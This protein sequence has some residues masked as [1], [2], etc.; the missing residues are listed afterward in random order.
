MQGCEFIHD[1]F[2]IFRTLTTLNNQPLDH[3]F[4]RGLKRRVLS[5]KFTLKAVHFITGLCLIIFSSFSFDSFGQKYP[6]ASIQDSLKENAD[7]VIRLHE[8][9]WDIKSA[10]QATLKR[11]VIYTILNEKGDDYAV[12]ASAY[13]NKSLLINNINGYLY[14][15]SGKE[16]R[17]FKKKDMEDLPYEDGVSFV[18]DERIKRGSFSYSRYPYTVEFDE[19]DELN[20]FI[21]IWNWIPQYSIKTSVELSKY[22]ITTPK[23]YVF[24]YRMLNST[25]QP[26][27]DDKGSKKI[28]TW[29]IANLSAYDEMPFSADYARY[30][31]RLLISLGEINIE[32]YKGSMTTWNEFGKF[33]GSLQK[34]RDLL[35]EET[36]KQV[37]SLTDGIHD[38]QTKVAILYKYLQ[39]NSHYVNVQLGIGG[40]QASEA[41]YVATKKYGDC[42]ALS[43]FMV[44][45]LKEAGIP[46]N[47]V[48]IKGGERDLDFITDFTYDPFNHVICCV[49]LNKDTI[50]L[51]CTDQYL[52][53]GYLSSFTANRYGLLIEE[54]G[55]KLVHTP[56]YLLPDNIRSRNLQA[57]LNPDGSLNVNSGTYYKALC[58]DK[59]ERM[60]HH[61][62]KDDQ[63]KILKSKFNLPTYDIV[64]FRYDEDYSKRLPVIHESLQ[65]DVKD[66][67]QITGK[68]IFINPNI[69]SR[70]GVKLSEDKDRRIDIDVKDEYHYLDTVQITI[71]PGY[72]VESASKDMISKSRFGKYGC[73]TIVE[74]NKL[75]YYREQEQYSGR[76]PASAYA[77]LVKFYEDIYEADNRSIVLVKQN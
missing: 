19:E 28:Y 11:H 67:A 23:D 56:A 75:V 59:I 74:G 66:Y 64:S 48:V 76:F 51:E 15:A 45:I 50:W 46:A 57:V 42:K 63:L 44:S 40:W 55:G 34:G 43:N 32:G 14:D 47:P 21:S 27:I 26:S 6:S 41:T 77:E 5:A 13:N 72:I 9:E 38:P 31:P 4:M 69:L 29:Q 70:S 30:S 35:P 53:P 52:P 33:Y 73:R 62:S 3:I 20:G 39:Q 25:I 60:I 24:T 1:N 18:N 71:P 8:M 10:G 36:K 65:I 61:N 49:P 58:Q 54:N 2:Y 17:H 22:S 7:V 37:H 12:Y 16:I 68:R